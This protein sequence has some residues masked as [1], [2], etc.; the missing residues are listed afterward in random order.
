MPG[1]QIFDP[2]VAEQASSDAF[3]S[4]RLAVGEI[5]DDRASDT[6]WRAGAAELQ[7]AE[8]EEPEVDKV[9]DPEEE[10]EDASSATDSE[11]PVADDIDGEQLET[12][13][14]EAV[15]GSHELENTGDAV[16]NA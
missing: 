5:I 6:T 4:S 7:E 14:D 2:P 1:R 16:D 12:A 8:E 3:W 11:V 10:E 15:D 9:V 13:D